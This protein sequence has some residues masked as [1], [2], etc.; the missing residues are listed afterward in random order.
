MPELFASPF[1][2]TRTLLDHRN[3]APVVGWPTLIAPVPPA[4]WGL[5]HQTTL[6]AWLTY[7]VLARDGAFENAH[8]QALSWRADH[9][10]VYG[11]SGSATAVVWK[12]AFADAAVAAS[13]AQGLGSRFPF[14]LSGSEIVIA[15]TNTTLP[16][17]W[18]FA[19]TA[20]FAATAA[21]GAPARSDGRRWWPRGNR[22]MLP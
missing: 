17:D 16:L 3:D 22:P 14:H 9:L 11:G 21:T 13:V 15:A 19:E 2:D 1:A 4:D 12:L 10:W 6:G 7:V 8:Q 20:A 5:T 18:A